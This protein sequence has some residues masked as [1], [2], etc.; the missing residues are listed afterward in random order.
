M[1]REGHCH[2]D[3]PEGILEP[4]EMLRQKLGPAVGE[5]DDLVNTGD[6]Q[7]ALEDLGPED[8][9]Q[10]PDAP[11]DLIQGDLIIGKDQVDLAV[12]AELADVTDLDA[13]CSR[14]PDQ[15]AGHFPADLDRSLAAGSS[16]ADHPGVG[17]DLKNDIDPGPCVFNA[18][19]I[20]L[21]A[22]LADRVK[23]G[24]QLPGIKLPDPFQI[25]LIP[26]L[27]HEPGQGQ[28]LRLRAGLIILILDRIKE[29]GHWLREH[30]ITDP[31]RGE[32]GRAEG[33]HIH[34]TAAAVQTLQGRRRLI[35][36]DQD[37]V[38][39]VFDHQTVVLLRPLKQ[40]LA[41]SFRHNGA[42]RE[43][44]LGTDIS[45]SADIGRK[46]FDGNAVL[47]D[48]DIADAET[49]VAEDAP[50]RSIAGV[51]C[52]DVLDIHQLEN[53]GQMVDQL[54]YSGA[55]DDLLR[56]ADD[57]PGTVQ[58]AGDL[59]PKGRLAL[60]VAFGQKK[61]RTL[62]QDFGHAFFPLLEIK[63]CRIGFHHILQCC[64][65]ICWLHFNQ[66]SLS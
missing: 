61:I 14:G 45:G 57:S 12:A 9:D 17:I 62:L 43:L 55:D 16:L 8:L 47:F 21:A 13:Q 46:L 18:D 36:S 66:C 7:T 34:D 32:E 24:P 52:A 22:V 15:T 25:L 59:R 64:L 37:A 19:K 30:H 5:T 6:V 33:A 28:L 58:V 20:A 23:G 60:L 54:L 38:I 29:L 51:F 50:Y 10:V 42:G 53:L 26:A 31:H 44:I 4:G 65:F 3:A 2:P 40:K 41:V 63:G 49:P 1:R 27:A 35:R 56:R 11:G 39:V 48:G